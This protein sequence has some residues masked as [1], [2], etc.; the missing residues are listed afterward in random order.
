[1]GGRE[2]RLFDLFSEADRLSTASGFGEFSMCDGCYLLAA[3]DMHACCG[4]ALPFGL[5]VS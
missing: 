2:R 4:V 5:S 3:A 1:M